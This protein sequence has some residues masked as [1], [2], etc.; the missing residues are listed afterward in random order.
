MEQFEN[1]T[2]SGHALNEVF[3][4][5]E[6]DEY[7]LHIVESNELLTRSGRIILICGDNLERA[8]RH[9]LAGSATKQESINE[10]GPPTR[11][12]AASNTWQFQDWSA[13]L[14]THYHG[15]PD[16]SFI[17]QLAD[18]G[19]GSIVGSWRDLNNHD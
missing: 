9:V 2:V 8:G 15:I 16:S 11:E 18:L 19:K 4:E 7:Q 5:L 6:G 3:G 1:L 17:L 14:L 12:E 10:F 13:K